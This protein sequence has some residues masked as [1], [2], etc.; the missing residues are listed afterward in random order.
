MNRYFAIKSIVIFL[1]CLSAVAVFAAD[2][3]SGKV[4]NQTTQRPAAGDDV[5][6]LRMGEGMQEEARVRTDAQ[7]TFSMNLSHPE[8]QYVL[9]VLHQG[10]NYD[11]TLTGASMVQ[12]E[13][14][15][16]T[17][18]IKGL[19]GVLGIAQVESDGATLKVTEMYSIA[20]GSVPPMTQTGPHNFQISLPVEATLDFFTAKRSQGIWVNLAAVPVPGKQGSYAVNFPLRP[21]DT[22]FKF[23][24]Y[25]PGSGVTTLHLKP[26]YPV[27]SFA[28]MHPPSMAFKALRPH[29]FT[30]PGVVKGL[31]VEQAVGGVGREVPAFEVSGVGAVAPQTALAKASP[32]AALTAAAGNSSK[33][34]ANAQSDVDQRNVD[35]RNLDQRKKDTWAVSLLTILAIAGGGFALWR[36]QKRIG[37]RPP[38]SKN[39]PVVQALKDELF[40]LETERSRGTMSEEQYSSTRD[41]LKL[42]LQR[43]MT[44][45]KA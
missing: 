31:Q 19:Q 42:S 11:H 5:V 41:A 45:E 23:S 1:C 20:N 17:P 24:Y 22:F 27:Q 30:S 34:P 35:Q 16:T 18:A 36:R 13:V 38:G 3:V 21:G 28:V 6:L 44:R 29:S 7:G 10:V 9:R 12:L 37:A 39:M 33:L 43:A 8:A 2:T 25:L 40:Q 26:A 4:L 15:D 14:F 32:S